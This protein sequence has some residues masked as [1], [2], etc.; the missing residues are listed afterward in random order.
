MSSI[1]RRH[2]VSSVSLIVVFPVFSC[3]IC[4][5][6]SSIRLAY[7]TTDRTPPWRMLS[8]TLIS[9]VMPNLVRIFAFKLLLR[10]LRIL[11]F[12]P[13]RPF[14]LITYRIAVSVVDVGSKSAETPQKLGK[15]DGQLAPLEAISSLVTRLLQT[16]Q[17]GRLVDE[18]APS[19]GEMGPLSSVSPGVGAKEATQ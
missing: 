4:F 12:F 10:F 16:A 18:K 6:I 7:S 11:Q 1:H 13:D 14:L 15:G 8:L 3:L 17:E 5:A 2:P 9:L 19:E